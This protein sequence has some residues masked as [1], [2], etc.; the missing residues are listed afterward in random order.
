MKE[1]KCR[2]VVLT[3]NES[4]LAPLSFSCLTSD[5]TI[6]DDILPLDDFDVTLRFNSEVLL[7]PEI[8]LLLG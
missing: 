8:G 2:V 3:Q 5:S 4:I 1:R 6:E 7:L